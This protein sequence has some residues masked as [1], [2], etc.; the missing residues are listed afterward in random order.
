MRSNKMADEPAVAQT[1]EQAR[2]ALGGMMMGESPAVANDPNATEQPDDIA[3]IFGLGEEVGPTPNSSESSSSG[4]ASPDGATPAAEGGQGQ[5]QPTTPATSAQPSTQSE[6][7]GDPTQA[8]A[9]QPTAAPAAPAAVT[10]QTGGQQPADSTSVQ[11]LAAQVQALVTQNAELQQRLAQGA[12]LA[13]QTGPGGQPGQQPQDVDP[14][15]DYRLAIPDDVASAVFHEDPA[16]ARQGIQHVINSLGRIVHERVLRSVT[17]RVL[18]SYLQEFQS[19]LTQS[20]QQEQMR[21]Q[22]YNDFPQHN[23]PGIKLIVAQEAQAMWT[24]NPTLAWDANARAALGARVNA[25]LG[26]PVV[27][28]AQGQ[29]Q[30]TTQ[31]APA[32]RPAAQMGASTRPAANVGAENDEISSILSA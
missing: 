31:P 8:P 26:Q 29:Q 19:N 10:E 18:P 5:A 14:Y 12:G 24:A 13:P 23:D 9:Q 1:Q 25:R 27:Q 32:P 4:G 30:Q 17:E 15:L 28:P 20:Q 21:Q 2:E 22:Y 3:S 11:A 16:V 7:Q 6:Q